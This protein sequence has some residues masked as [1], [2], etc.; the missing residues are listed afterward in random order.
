MCV[1]KAHDDSPVDVRPQEGPSHL[2]SSPPAFGEI[3]ALKRGGEPSLGDPGRVQA[4][5]PEHDAQPAA[6]NGSA[7][8]GA[9]GSRARIGWATAKDGVKRL[10]LPPPRTPRRTGRGPVG[11]PVWDQER[12]VSAPAE[13]PLGRQPRWGTGS[14]EPEKRRPRDTGA[15][16]AGVGAA[17]RT[18]EAV[19]TT[20]TAAGRG[21]AWS[22]GSAG[23]SAGA[24]RAG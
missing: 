18:G 14:D 6:P 24:G 11:Q 13:R 8:E 21:R 20:T 19:D 22:V 23:V 4:T 9:P 17:Q 10:A 7:R 1:L 5:G 15:S 2:C 12:P 16:G 3:R